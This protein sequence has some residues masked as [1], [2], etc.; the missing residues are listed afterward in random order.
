[1][2]SNG[3]G[4][5]R[6][7]DGRFNP[8]FK[9]DAA[10]DWRFSNLWWC[11]DDAALQCIIRG[12]LHRYAKADGLPSLNIRAVSEDQYANIWIDTEDAGLIKLAGK[13]FIA[14]DTKIALIRIPFFAH[15][16]RLSN[17]WLMASGGRLGCLH[18]GKFEAFDDQYGLDQ[19]TLTALYEDRESNIW[20][21][22]YHGLYLKRS[23]VIQSISERE[24]LWSNLVYSIIQDHSGTVWVGTYDRGLNNR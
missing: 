16:D 10:C 5:F 9:P 15:E 21:G 13:E 7:E 17:L 14:Y 23:P 1:L 8:L 6:L 20:I 2:I 12:R 4:V 19:Y 11:K 24:E 22:T 3:S 18:G